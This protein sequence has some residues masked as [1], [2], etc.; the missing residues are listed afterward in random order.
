MRETMIRSATGLVFGLVV[1]GSIVGGAWSNALLWILVGL[2][3]IREFAKGMKKPS[4]AKVWGFAA[5]LGL[6][7]SLIIGIPW[8]SSGGYEPSV[9]LSM[10]FMI[11]VND[12]GAYFVGKPLGKNKLA[13]R[14]SPGKSWEGFAGGVFFSVLLAGWLW[15]WAYAWIGVLIAVSATAGD[16]VE[17]AWKRR[18]GLKDSGVLL[19]GHGGILDRFDG[20]MITAPIY[21]IVLSLLPLETSLKALLP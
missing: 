18:N 10:I 2:L 15:G 1:I 3:A 19:P 11:W 17:S 12:S 5:F 21:F 9:L 4:L 14:I 8:Q 20:F 6:W 13:P 16:L 7:L